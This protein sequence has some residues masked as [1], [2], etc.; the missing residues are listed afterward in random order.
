MPAIERREVDEFVHNETF[1]VEGIPVEVRGA[2]DR[3]K[4]ESILD[5]VR[6]AAVLIPKE[7]RFGTRIQIF[8]HYPDRE[9][10]E[11]QGGV[12]G[13]VQVSKE[14]PNVSL[15]QIFPRAL[16]RSDHLQY[17]LGHEFGE[18]VWGRLSND[19]KEEVGKGFN[20]EQ[21]VDRQ[22][23]SWGFTLPK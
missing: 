20:K 16:A 19:K 1:V 15:I 18:V 13:R 5:E 11:Y 4:F 21:W 22:A 6:D 17:T 3:V 7:V 12:Y 10:R 9:S 23:K 8:D 2:F 14:D